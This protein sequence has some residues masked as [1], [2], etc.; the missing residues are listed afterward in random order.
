VVLVVAVFAASTKVVL[1]LLSKKITNMK[2]ILATS[3]ETLE[4]DRESI[5]ALAN[6]TENGQWL[7]VNKCAFL[8]PSVYTTVLSA[9]GNSIW[10]CD[11]GIV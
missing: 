6:V 4:G 7:V 5:L 11:C 10:I 1:A 2:C 3:C 9:S 8:Y